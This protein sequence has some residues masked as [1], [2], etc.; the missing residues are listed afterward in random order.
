[1]KEALK[2]VIEAMEKHGDAYL[3]HST[4]YY[5][6]IEAAKE[7]LAKQE[8]GEPVAIGSI[9]HLKTMMEESAF[10]G[11]LELSDALLNIDEFYTTPQQR[12]PL[13]DEQIDEIIKASP[14]MDTGYAGWVRDQR[15][16]WT[17]A[18][19]AAHGITP[20]GSNK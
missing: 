4:E 8:Q 14:K 10:E 1:M 16:A 18:I 3:G 11:R 15:R 5:L 20:Q 12:K 13:T 9:Q 17:R 7:A 6:A 2:L 19:E